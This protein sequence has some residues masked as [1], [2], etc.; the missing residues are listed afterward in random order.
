MNRQLDCVADVARA[1]PTAPTAATALAKRFGR[2]DPA[3][4]I[5]VRTALLLA[6]LA[7]PCVIAALIDPR[8]LNGVSVWAKPLKFQLSFA[9]HWLTIAWLLGC[10]DAPVRNRR[11]TRIV[12][13]LGAFAALVEV[14]YI[15]L[16]AAR[17][18][19]SH[20]NS[21]TPLES[22]LY[23]ALMGGA[24]VVMMAVTLWIGLLIWRHPASG[25]RA[26]LWLGA[27]FG[28]VI[29]SAVTLI[30]TA[31]LAS[32]NLVGSGHW[33]VSADGARLPVLDWS[34]TGGDMRVP[35]FAATHLV[36]LLPVAGW[37]ADRYAA[38][39]AR[40][41][42]LLTLVAGLSVVAMLAAGAVAGRPL[43]AA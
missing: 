22:V 9:L 20:F 23:Y 18:R 6:V 31:P 10:L 34:M 37:M 21:A 2:D 33:L 41:I 14:L 25:R 27:V 16:Q 30:V 40:L 43:F 1:A 8:N 24:A 36:Q 42:V 32:G 4:Q 15:T 29:G 12:L 7:L 5:A 35:H 11:S 38:Q 19:H 13:E 39:S 3:T 26:G 28:L 17:G